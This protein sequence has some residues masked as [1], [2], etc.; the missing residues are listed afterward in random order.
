MST[1]QERSSRRRK[2]LLLKSAQEGKTLQKSTLASAGDQNRVIFHLIEVF[3][4]K[5][6]KINVT[7]VLINNVLG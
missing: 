3:G 1:G 4:N 7:W 2:D 5:I 6:N